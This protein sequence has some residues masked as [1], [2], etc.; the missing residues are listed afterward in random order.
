MSK[1]CRILGLIP[2]ARESESGGC[3]DGPARTSELL[4]VA[5]GCNGGG[6]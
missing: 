2:H 3:R 6:V 1:E 5:N 4:A